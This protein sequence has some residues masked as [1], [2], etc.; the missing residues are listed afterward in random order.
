MARRRNRTVTRQRQIA[1]R[2][3]IARSKSAAGPIPSEN[4][5]IAPWA[6]LAFV[7]S[8]DLSKFAQLAVPMIAVRQ[9]SQPISIEQSRAACD[10]LQTELATHG[11]FAGYVV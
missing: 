7:E 10:A 4:D 2:H 11:D 5:P 8:T 3:P 1:G 6:Q 9:M